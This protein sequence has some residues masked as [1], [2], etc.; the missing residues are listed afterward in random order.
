MKKASKILALILVLTIALTLL[1]ACSKK[2]GTNNSPEGS[3]T[4]S[5][6][7]SPDTK[8]VRV[9]IA[10]NPATLE[11]WLF[12]DEGRNDVMRN[13]YEFL[14]DISS[15]GGELVPVIASGYEKID[16]K[17]YNITLYPNVKD[18]KGNAIT[19]E[20]VVFSYESAIALGFSG[21][22]LGVIE[23]VKALDKTTVQFTFKS[24]SAGS[25]ENA[26][27]YTPIISK[28]E[29]EKD[30][31]AFIS[32]PVG[33]GAYVVKEH[34]PGSSLTLTKNINYWQTDDKLRAKFSQAN[35]GN[36][37]Y[38]VIPESSQLTIALE[39]GT[40]D[41]GYFVAT[42]D[43]GHFES[44]AYTVLSAPK[45]RADMLIFNGEEG[46]VFAN[47]KAL[48]EAVCYAI[49]KQVILQ[50]TYNGV[51]WTCKTFGSSVFADY[52]DKWEDEDYFDYDIEKAKALLKEAGYPNGLSVRLL[53]SNN[54]NHI[55]MAQIVQ[56]M[57]G[58]IG[59]TVELVQVDQAAFSNVVRVDPS[60]AP[61]D[62][63]IDARSAFDYVANVWAFNF[64]A[65]RN[66]GKTVNFFVDDKLQSLV[67]TAIAID[68]HT[69]ENIDAVH[70]YLKE[71]CI[72]MGLCYATNNYVSTSTITNF[73]MDFKS[74]IVPGACTY[75]ADFVG[76]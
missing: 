75:S 8:T 15:I 22:S 38:M 14:F 25:F 61:W 64:D 32:N 53:T 30:P 54:N 34:I 55:K 20:D 19:S 12:I 44:D 66:N 26:V 16:E 17:T 5:T 1:A 72:A 48:R 73:V 7:D 13:I 33:T 24:V 9:G 41:V 57:L 18:S 68:T 45:D 46:N 31:S 11:P 29:Y 37:H 36:I 43:L 67:K 42:S 27:G 71:I 35:I 70:Q 10:G 69:P 6:A 74:R 56:N 52:L 4:D 58:Q 50:N 51:G 63:Y 28:A 3:D 2:E 76:K 59:I 47:N 23:S 21:M 49:D 62:L 65:E 39:T 40:I 60:Q